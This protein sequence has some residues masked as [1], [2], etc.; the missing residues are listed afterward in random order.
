[1]PSTGSLS[2]ATPCRVNNV[3]VTAPPALR[4]VCCGALRCYVFVALSP[5]ALNMSASFLNKTSARSLNH[6]LGS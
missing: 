1:M 4:N 6:R 2:N 5:A 3:D